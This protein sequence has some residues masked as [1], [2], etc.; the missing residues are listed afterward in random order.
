MDPRPIGVFDSGVGGL[1]VLRAL[2]AAMPRESFVYLGDTARLPYGTKGPETVQRYA[3]QAAALLVARDV[4]MLVVACNTAS[5]VALLSLRA[6]VKPIPVMGVVEPGARA[7][8]R[9]STCKKVAVLATP[10]TVRGR[11]YETAIESID[12]AVQV[13]SIPCAVFVALA[14]EGWGTGAV[15]RAAVAA[16]LAPLRPTDGP[17]AASVDAVVLGCTHFPALRQEIEA[18]L[19]PNI[20]VVDSAQ[21]TANAVRDALHEAS[22]ETNAASGVVK[23][24]ATD[25]SESFA[26]NAARF[27]GAPVDARSIERVDL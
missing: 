17:T 15:A 27:L 2:R 16:Y 1:T 3:S 6:A 26:R 4:K 8:C 14:E 10:G 7:V 19:G 11:A 23:F 12:P 9:A 21:T 20:A 18:F 5:S 22:L 24:L 25:E 13:T